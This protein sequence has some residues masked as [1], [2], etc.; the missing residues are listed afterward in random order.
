MQDC[1]YQS[2][3]GTY[4]RTPLFPQCVGSLD[5]NAYTYTCVTSLRLFRCTYVLQC[6]THVCASPTWNKQQTAKL[7]TSLERHQL[8][9]STLPCFIKPTDHTVALLRRPASERAVINAL[10]WPAVLLSSGLLAWAGLVVGCCRIERKEP[11]ESE[12][13]QRELLTSSYATENEL[14]HL[15][16]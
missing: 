7:Q 13:L 16:R 6:F 1:C 12:V 5:V 8:Q 11:H 4:A 2:Y 9:R 14:T 15:R 3:H 10:L